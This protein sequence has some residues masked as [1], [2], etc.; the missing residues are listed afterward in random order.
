MDQFSYPTI[1][2]KQK[3]HKKRMNEEQLRL[4]ESNFNFNNKLDPEHKSRLALELGVP[5]RQV[6]IWYQNKRARD[7]IHGLEADHRAM[8]AQLERVLT[9]NSRLRDEVERLREE[10]I[11]ARGAAALGSFNSSRSG[12][13]VGSLVS[14]DNM[15]RDLYASLVGGG[16]PFDGYDFF[17]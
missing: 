3:A 4:L 12:D 13:E 2:K 10:L 8:R 5:P 16:G 15:E 6:A 11:R 1:R 14:G 17:G 9:D 7:K